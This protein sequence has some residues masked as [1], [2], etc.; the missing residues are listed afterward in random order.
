MIQI[1][2]GQFREVVAVLKQKRKSVLHAEVVE[3]RD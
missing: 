3:V 2:L 1:P